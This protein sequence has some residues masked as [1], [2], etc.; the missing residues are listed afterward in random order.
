LL[1][2]FFQIPFSIFVILIGNETLSRSVLVSESGKSYLR[3]NQVNTV[4]V[5]ALMYGILGQNC[6]T[7]SAVWEGMLS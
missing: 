2:L 7:E 5:A 6:F 1:Q 3:L 4:Q